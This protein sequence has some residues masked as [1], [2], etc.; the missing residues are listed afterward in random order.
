MRCVGE[1]HHALA[2]SNELEHI[3]SLR[4]APHLLRVPW[5]ILCIELGYRHMFLRCF[6]FYV[7]ILPD[8]FFW[9]VLSLVV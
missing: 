7:Y 1:R 2:T 8:I 4:L 9:L 6:M 3:R 5:P